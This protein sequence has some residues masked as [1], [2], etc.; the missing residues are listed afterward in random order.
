MI[1]D[2]FYLDGMKSAPTERA[3]QRIAKSA[4]SNLKERISIMSMRRT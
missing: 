4:I 3:I 1:A 2:L